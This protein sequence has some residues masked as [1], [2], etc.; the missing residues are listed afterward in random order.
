VHE[1]NIAIFSINID[2][3]AV[4][5]DTVYA[6]RTI[7]EV[8]N[9]FV[10]SRDRTIERYYTIQRGAP[11]ASTFADHIIRGMWGPLPPPDDHDARK[12]AS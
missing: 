6:Y 10:G 4:S 2:A 3:L 1:R 12:V 11:Y 8:R 5:C 9:Q 7:D